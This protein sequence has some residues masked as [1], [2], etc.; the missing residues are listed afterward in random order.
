MPDKHRFFVEMAVAAIATANYWRYNV[1]REYKGNKG[2][3]KVKKRALTLLLALL[4]SLTI[5]GCDW[6]SGKDE[7][8]TAITTTT[9]ATT[10]TL[11][12]YN[13]AF[14]ENGG[15]YVADLT[16]PAGQTL[17]EPLAPTK[18]GYAFAGWYADSGLS[19][20]Y[21]F[22]VMPSQNLPLYAK[23]IELS[24]SETT[25]ADMNALVAGYLPEATTSSKIQ[26][27]SLL[28]TFTA[29]AQATSI[30]TELDGIYAGFTFLV[31]L[32]FTRD[33]DKIDF[34]YAKTTATSLMEDSLEMLN[35]FVTAEL[36]D[37]FQALQVLDNY[38]AMINGAESIEEVDQYL[39]SFITDMAA[40]IEF[41]GPPPEEIVAGFKAASI[42]QLQAVMTSINAAGAT[43]GIV[44]VSETDMETL[45][46]A[47]NATSE[48]PEIVTQV[49][50]GIRQMFQNLS[51]QSREY[52]TI[53][54]T[55][56][57]GDAQANL[58]P[59]DHT[60]VTAKYQL[61]LDMI[62]TLHF[63]DDISEAATDFVTMIETCFLEP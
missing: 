37:D 49:F 63:F 45:T 38:L 21:D 20:P 19:I 40:A 61:A 55:G 48:I 54:V 25:I 22:T 32:A 24:D 14:E 59:E 62:D 50:H 53:L 7:S 43:I 52:F 3:I 57:Y 47:I 5:M 33:Y 39:D 2:E 51:E 42:A 8:T 12:Q 17:T 28:S 27:N 4:A 16:G 29:L 34:L 15:S 60:L 56:V 31:R 41:E 18:A 35:L 44:P 1:D 13:I 10:T 23:W 6:F 9:T 46:A 26:M 30:K 11:A 58:S 36:W